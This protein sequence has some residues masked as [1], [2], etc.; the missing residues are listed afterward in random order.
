M[1]AAEVERLRRAAPA[2]ARGCFGAVAAPGAT[3]A[4]G[5]HQHDAPFE[6]TALEPFVRAGG[7]G[8]RH[9]GVGE[10]RPS[11]LTAPYMTKR[12]AFDRRGVGPPQGR[13]GTLVVAVSGVAVGGGRGPSRGA[14]PRAVA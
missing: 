4:P 6:I 12:G 10:Q 11:P 9:D 5:G 14:A 13:I 2:A 8:Q 3:Y 1:P 7:V